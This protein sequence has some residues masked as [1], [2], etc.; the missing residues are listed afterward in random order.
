M[1]AT[2]T[3]RQAPSPSPPAATRAP[4]S[5]DALAK[6][7]PPALTPA[8]TQTLTQTPPSPPPAPPPSST[9]ATITGLP[10]R[11]AEA[12]SLRNEQI[13]TAEV[14]L[15]RGDHA[16]AAQLLMPWAE[17]GVPRAQTLLGR[18]KENRSGNEQSN[19]EAYVWYSIA[20]RGGDAAAAAQRDKVAAR[21]QAAEIRQ[22]EQ[23]VERWRPRADAAPAGNP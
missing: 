4:Q 15:R 13:D 1:V 10:S 12:R 21:L 11:V 5:S 20:A 22:A 19:F 3:P 7:P 14:A 9:T 17:A 2:P 8:P 18:V 6:A 16:A 23:A